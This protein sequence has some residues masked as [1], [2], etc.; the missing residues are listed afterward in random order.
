MIIPRGCLYIKGIISS[1]L[2]NPSS[3]FCYFFLFQSPFQLH[4]L[5]KTTNSECKMHK[6]RTRQMSNFEFEHVL[7]AQLFYIKNVQNA[8]YITR[9]HKF[10]RWASY[11]QYSCN[12]L[13]HCFPCWMKQ[14]TLDTI[15]S[16][17]MYVPEAHGHCC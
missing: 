1:Q 9:P 16:I 13:P 4:I 7:Y 15:K 14:Q 17:V 11:I 10:L 12:L 8:Y 6:P 2:P 5:A 3:E